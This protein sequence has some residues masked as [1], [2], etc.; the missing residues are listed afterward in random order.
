MKEILFFNKMQHISDSSHTLRR[1]G[2]GFIIRFQKSRMCKTLCKLIKYQVHLLLV[3]EFVM[4]IT[5][6]ANQIRQYKLPT[7]L[8][9]SQV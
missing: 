3:R 1:K 2:L 8:I 6:K 9:R 4:S 5:N 7:K